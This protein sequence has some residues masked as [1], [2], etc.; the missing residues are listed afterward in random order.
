VTVGDDAGGGPETV[1]GTMAALVAAKREAEARADAAEGRAREVEARLRDLEGELDRFQAA[2]EAGRALV[3]DLRREGETLRERAARAEGEV[4]GLRE[5]I[6]LAE[7]AR[8]EAVARAAAAEADRARLLALPW[9]RRL[10]G[11]T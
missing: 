8:Q 9:W 11:G 10:L 1:A 6:R 4:S 2:A 5:V 3:A 7:A